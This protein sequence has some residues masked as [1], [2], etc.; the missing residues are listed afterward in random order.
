MWR[1]ITDVLY[2][3]RDQWGT[4]MGGCPVVWCGRRGCLLGYVQTSKRI[5]RIPACSRRPFRDPAAGSELLER[6]AGSSH[7][8]TQHTH[9]LSMWEKLSRLPSRRQKN[10]L[11]GRPTSHRAGFWVTIVIR[12]S[13]WRIPPSILRIAPNRQWQRSQQPRCRWGTGCCRPSTVTAMWV[14][15]ARLGG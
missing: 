7:R 3:V 14:Q 4:S 8:S 9:F 5:H 10:M 12:F 11:F 15:L 1:Q 6:R 13:F 2:V